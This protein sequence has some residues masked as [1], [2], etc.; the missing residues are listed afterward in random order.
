MKQISIFPFTPRHGHG[1]ADMH[2]SKYDMLLQGKETQNA[3]QI[4]DMTNRQQEVIN[5]IN[6][7]EGKSETYVHV[8][9]NNLR[10]S[11]SSRK[12]QL[13]IPGL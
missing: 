12:P 7:K 2:F 8:H 10:K 6:R 5:Y 3:Q 13:C 9:V 4:A 11:K 1:I